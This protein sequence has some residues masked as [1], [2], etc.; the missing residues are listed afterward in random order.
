[1]AEYRSV[2]VAVFEDERFLGSGL[3][4]N[5]FSTKLDGYVSGVFNAARI[6]GAMDHTPGKV[7]SFNNP[8]R[9]K[10]LD[11]LRRTHPHLAVEVESS[12][13]L[14]SVVRDI[15]VYE[16][17]LLDERVLGA[18]EGLPYTVTTEDSEKQPPRDSQIP[19]LLTRN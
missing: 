6:Y 15:R 5:G 10:S 18:I 4:I 3:G 1:M 2:K 9:F 17:Q 13:R 11:E 19:I 14:R 16:A 7:Q 12:S 8:E